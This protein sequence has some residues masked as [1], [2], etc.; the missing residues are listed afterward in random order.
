MCG[1]KLVCEER[2]LSL[3]IER[4][5]KQQ[6][7]RHLVALASACSKRKKNMW[8]NSTEISKNKLE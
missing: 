3:L 8:N 4:F 1:Y 6:N 5:R 2:I 7:G